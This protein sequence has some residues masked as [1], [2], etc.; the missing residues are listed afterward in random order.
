MCFFFGFVRCARLCTS[1]GETLNNATI[2]L[3]D[4][5]LSLQCQNMSACTNYQTICALARLLLLFRLLTLFFSFAAFVSTLLSFSSNP[6][7]TFFFLFIIHCRFSL[8][9]VLFPSIFFSYVSIERQYF[10]IFITWI[11]YA[12]G[13]TCCLFARKKRSCVV[14]NRGHP[15]LYLWTYFYWVS[16]VKQTAAEITAATATPTLFKRRT[17]IFLACDY[18]YIRL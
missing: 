13:I 5:V 14:S 15:F 3:L 7:E 6:N 16:F 17:R 2:L 12:F 10:F 9:F 8:Y 11:L 1:F 4:F 18:Y